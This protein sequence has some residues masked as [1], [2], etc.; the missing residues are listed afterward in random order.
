M[1][2]ALPTTT[3]P[4]K[5]SHWRSTDALTWPWA[6]LP[7]LDPLRPASGSGTVRYPTATRLCADVER[8]YVHFD[9]HDPDIW[10][11]LTQRDGPIYDEEVVEVFIAPGEAVPATYYEFEVSPIGTMLDLIAH[12]PTG[13]RRHMRTDFSWDCPGLVWSVQR[14]DADKRWAAILSLPWRSIGADGEQ[15]P[16]IWRANFYRI[17]RPH[18]APPE[19]TC[20]SPTFSDPAD[21]HRPAYFG[22]LELPES[23]AGAA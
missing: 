7:A 4:V 1:S 16:R 3:V 23:L 15:L 20:W 18:G 9:C 8:L 13:D 22:Y 11:T 17:E 2:V 19:F 14:M 21:Y 12:N 10:G 6:E 5:P